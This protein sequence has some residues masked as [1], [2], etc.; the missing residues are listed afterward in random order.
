MA[1]QVILQFGSIII[2]LNVPIAP[3]ANPISF[4]PQCFPYTNYVYAT[5]IVHN[6]TSCNAQ[7]HNFYNTL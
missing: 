6:E 2:A 3:F 7:A 4:I 5:T 1:N